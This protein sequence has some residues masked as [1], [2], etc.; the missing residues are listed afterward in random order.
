MYL[1][2]LIAVVTTAIT[3]LLIGLPALRLRGDYLAIVTLGL[4]EVVRILANNLDHPIN[5]TNGPQ[6]ITPVGRPH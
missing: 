6:G 4:G 1:F 5:I 2:M 3:G